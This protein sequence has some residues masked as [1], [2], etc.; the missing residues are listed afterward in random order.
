M[1]NKMNQYI[2]RLLGQTFFS[3]DDHHTKTFIFASL[4]IWGL[5]ISPTFA[6]NCEGEWQE[7]GG[8]ANGAVNA[9]IAFDDGSGPSI[10]AAGEFTSIDGIAASR[11]ARWDGSVWS[12]LGTGLNQRVNALAVFDSG[13][14]PE[15]YAAGDF[16]NAGGVPVSRIAKWDGKSWSGVGSGL[17]DTANAL[18]VLDDGDGGSLYATGEFTFAGG[19]AA[20]RIAKWTG[21][22][23]RRLGTS[24]LR[25]IDDDFLPAEGS[26]MAVYDDGTGRAL[27][28]GGSFAGAGFT[29]SQ[30]IVKW[31]GTF[32]A[33]PLVGDPIEAMTVHDDG[34][35]P[36]LYFGG[37]FTFPGNRVAKWDGDHYS[38]LGTGLSGGGFTNALSLV[39]VNSVTGPRLLAGGEFGTAGLM[40]A[41][42]IAQWDGQSWE[43]L[44]VGLDGFNRTVRALFPIDNGS[45]VTV[46]AG[47]NFTQ[48]G[49]LN[50]DRIASWNP[51]VFSCP[52]DLA[53]P[54]GTLNFSDLVAYLAA[55]NNADPAADFADP[56]GTLNFSDLL[57][58]L[59]AF[60]AGCP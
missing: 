54:F 38:P 12:P 53:E 19:S 32:V 25:S 11:I 58:F 42:N 23:W 2:M 37:R 16:V 59:A 45:G 18:A 4:L 44:G 52:A 8:G 51:C 24:G 39:S 55:F 26:A 13:S 22:Q 49:D 40:A 41:L 20:S 47:G 5:C 29:D 50:I 35:G 14:G 30:N 28:I 7:F 34:S 36:A 1:R 57:A 48:S 31:N 46:I 43:P 3:A 15:L 9:F 27:Y 60:N 6:Q 17:N 33:M 21:S 10:Y 56:I